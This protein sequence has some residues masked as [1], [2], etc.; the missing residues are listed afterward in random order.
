MSYTDRED[1]VIDEEEGDSSHN[2]GAGGGGRGG[3]DVDGK[4]EGA[5]AGVL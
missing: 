1:G 2:R 5:A 3:V 4:A